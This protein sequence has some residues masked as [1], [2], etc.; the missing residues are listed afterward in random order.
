M[1][2]CIVVARYNENIEWTKQFSNVIIYNKGA[3]LE[4]KYNEIYLN[5][6]GREG[7]TYYK[8]IYDN[9]ENLSDYTIFLQA[10]PFD[11]SPNIISNLKKYV[12]NTELNIDF[13]FLSEKIIP[14]NLSTRQ[15]HGPPWDLPLKT[16]YE[17][18]FNEK[19][20]N[21][22][23]K[24]GAGAQF[25]VSKKYIL[26]W[27]KEFYLKIIEMLGKSVSPIEG[28]VIE[29][30]HKL[31]LTYNKIMNYPLLISK[32]QIV[33]IA[34]EFIPKNQ[35]DEFKTRI[36]KFKEHQNTMAT[37]IQ[38]IYRGRSSRKFWGKGKKQIICMHN[39]GFFSN[40]SVL[41]NH[42]VDFI[43]KYNMYP[44]DIETGNMWLRYRDGPISK[45]KP[46]MI[47]NYFEDHKIMKNVK[48]KHIT[49]IDYQHKYQYKNFDELDYKNIIP[50]TKRYF[51]PC[52]N[53]QELIQE[54]ENKYHID[55]KNVCALFYRGN[56]KANEMKLPDYDVFFERTK[57]ILELNPSTIFLI[58]SDETEF[59]DFFSSKYPNNSF[60]FKDEIRHMTK[61][62]STVDAMGKNGLE[63]HVFHFS[64]YFLAIIIIM[65]KCESIIC[66]K[67]NCSIW[68]VFYRGNCENVYQY[69]D[70]CWA[71]ECN[72]EK[73]KDGSLL[74]KVTEGEILKINSNTKILSAKY[75]TEEKYSIIPITQEFSNDCK[76]GIRVSN[77]I[78]GDAHPNR[79]KKLSVCYIEVKN[80]T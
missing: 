36:D 8:H 69:L 28:Y 62:N 20:E 12:N 47:D 15:T 38:K 52:E 55:Y 37:R 49:K 31:I 71:D 48:I 54:L 64:Q 67:G 70:N 76:N 4:G 57:Q 40:C 21:M 23:F 19:K 26:Q 9:Y 66:T 53:I 14:C 61:R 50:L 59:I 60:Y 41:L 13:E 2:F 77:K 43:N 18:L 65:S 5:N 24:F 3:P 39:H 22:E 58:Q 51:S 1:K 32:N 79:L 80:T 75:G 10:N 46:L 29:R 33:D 27:P 34:S 42:I 63:G 72:I 16:T 25:I 17:K 45:R 56:D 35:L 30:F 78:F 74:L 68:I 11:H 6:V 7:H 44:N 73:I